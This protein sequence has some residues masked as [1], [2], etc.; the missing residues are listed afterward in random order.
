[1]PNTFTPA[2]FGCIECKMWYLF[3]IHT[4]FGFNGFSLNFAF[5]LRFAVSRIHE[6]GKDHNRHAPTMCQSSGK[7]DGYVF[8]HTMK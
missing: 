3:D 5:Q 6:T 4:I 1:M 8:T 7:I 2:N